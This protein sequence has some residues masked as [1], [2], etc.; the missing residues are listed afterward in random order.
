MKLSHIFTGD[1]RPGNLFNV[2]EQPINVML[3]V[4]NYCNNHCLFCYNP[5][6]AVYRNDKPDIASL[7]RIVSLIGENGTKEIL[8]LGGEPFSFPEMHALLRAGKKYDMFQRAVSNGTFLNNKTTC[9]DLKESG[10]DEVG[11]SF[12]SARETVHDQLAGRKGSFSDAMSAIENS[13]SAGITTFIQYSPTRLNSVGDIIELG[14]N[15]KKI[16]GNGIVYFDINRLLPLGQGNTHPDLF[17]EDDN[18]FRFLCEASELYQQ[19]F[20]VHAELTPFC[21]LKSKAGVYG[22]ADNILDALFRSNRGC[23]MWVAQ[24]ALDHRGRIKFCP[25]GASIG[26]SLLDVEWPD[27]WKTWEGFEQYRSFLW[28]D[29][30]IDFETKSARNFL[31]RC[32]GGCKYSKGTH[33]EVDRYAIDY[34]TANNNREGYA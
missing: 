7:E 33:Y 22:I 9:R 32:L 19:E 6:N 10:L 12:H 20:D 17:I 18:W 2:P 15:I 23:F 3:D 1:I 14:T 11:I 29:I 8:Y 28:N 27:F 31:Y 21:W 4:T 24:L 26:P 30:C 13:L 16:F 34:F 5:G 25:A